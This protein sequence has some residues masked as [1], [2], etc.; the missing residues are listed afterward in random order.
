[1]KRILKNLFP[2]RRYARKILKAGL[3]DHFHPYRSLFTGS[4]EPLHDLTPEQIQ[5]INQS[6][7]KYYEDA[8]RSDF[9]KNKPFSDAKWAPW[10]L[11]R[12]GLLLSALRIRPGDKVLDFG[13]GTGWTSIMLAQMGAEVRG[14]DVSEAALNLGRENAVRLL[15]SEQQAR[16]RFEV[17]HENSIPAEDGF[18]DYVFVFEAIHHLPNPRAILREFSRVL[19]EYGYFGFA[20]PGI[21]HSATHSSIE[22]A[23]LGI[24]EEDLDLE[25][26]YRTGIESGFKELEILIPALSPDMLT[27]P[28]KRARRFLRG[29]SWL[30]PADFMRTAILRGPIGV[31]RK[32]EHPIT[33]LH[34]KTH[35]AVIRSSQKRVSVV[36]GSPFAIHAEIQNPTDTVWLKKSRHGRGYVRLG[37]HLINAGGHVEE[38]DFGRADLLRDMTQEQSEKITLNLTAPPNPGDYTVR[39]DLV[40]EGI[41]WFES[42]GSQTLDVP[43]LVIPK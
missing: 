28:M 32:T 17:F 41:C 29:L 43:L 1:M 21:G 9:W 20:E 18:F 22:E 35:A 14:L 26:L 5:Q 38:F 24:L 3:P 33:S 42:E 15:S 31:F 37:A 23:A 30:V 13:C 16:I 6:S 36:A 40:N 7:A 8:S 4:P 19:N 10:F 11:W 25:R 12:F 2:G 34:P 27:L 39:L